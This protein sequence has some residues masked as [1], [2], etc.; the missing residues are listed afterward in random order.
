VL[1]C[2]A[3]HR[4]VLDADGSPALGPDR[5]TSGVCGAPIRKAALEFVQTARRIIDNRQLGLTLIGVGGVNSGQHVQDM[6][7]TGA[8][9]VQ[10][11]TGMMWNPLLAH[12]YHSLQAQQQQQVCGQEGQLAGV[13]AECLEQQQ[14]ALP[15]ACV[16]GAA[17]Q[18]AM[19][20]AASPVVKSAA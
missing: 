9:F 19:G 18:P 3:F 13:S 10:S 2:N 14:V 17:K 7:N 1:E 15:G 12:E 8:D 6:L 16:A 20:A 5:P 4:T 11:A